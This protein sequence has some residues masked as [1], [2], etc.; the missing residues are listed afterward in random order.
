[1]KKVMGGSRAESNN[2]RDPPLPPLQDFTA[3]PVL[4]G[5]DAVALYPSLDMV[6]TIEMV[7]SVIIESEVEFKNVDLKPLLVYLTLVLG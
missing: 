1:M 2:H 6:G 7:A 5:G 3:K 4:I